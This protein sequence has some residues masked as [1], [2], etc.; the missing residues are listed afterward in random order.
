MRKT[1]AN[2]PFLIAIVMLQGRLLQINQALKTTVRCVHALP[3][4]V[5]TLGQALCSPTAILYA[6]REF[7]KISPPIFNLL[8]ML[9]RNRP[10]S[11]HIKLLLFLKEF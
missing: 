11:L 8:V 9:L 4:F 3:P 5:N 2:Q 7:L 6:L 1:A 10:R